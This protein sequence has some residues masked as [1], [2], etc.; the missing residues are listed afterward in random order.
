MSNDHWY[1]FASESRVREYLNR[2]CVFPRHPLIPHSKGSRDLPDNA[3]ANVIRGFL[4]PEGGD[5]IQRATPA[6]MHAIQKNTAEG[7][8]L[9]LLLVEI[10]PEDE[11]YV[12][13]LGAF[14]GF[15]H[16][17]PPK[18]A[19]PDS[20]EGQRAKGE[21][22]K[23]THGF[24]DQFCQTLIPLDEYIDGFYEQPTILSFSAVP[25]ERARPQGEPI[26]SFTHHKPV[27]NLKPF[28]V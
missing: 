22:N 27:M 13:D 28:M 7:Q 8:P 19:S 18:G 6:Q 17:K 12:A 5:S 10:A 1:H 15:P 16:Y 21:F 24:Y 26:C 3:H 20:D 11:L 14:K 23:R 25:L 9:Y 4:T 2:G